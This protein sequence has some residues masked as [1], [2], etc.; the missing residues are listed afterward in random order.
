MTGAFSLP[1]LQA[2]LREG[3]QVAGVM[4]R[5]IG[6]PHRIEPP[7]RSQSGLPVLTTFV[8]PNIVQLA[9]Q[10]GIPVFEAG[11]FQDL[12]VLETVEPDVIAV[13]CFSR[14]LPA[15]LRG[16]ARLA[17]INVHPSLLP[18]NRGPDP[19][20]WTLA[21]GERQTGVTVHLLS[22]RADAGDILA[23]A[24][25]EVP[26]GI[27]RPDLERRCAGVGGEL[28]VEVIRQLQAGTATPIPQDESQA[29]YHR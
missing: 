22:D 12:R 27:T 25:V 23:Q 11:S 16:L 29:T 4:V 15:R 6:E 19:I 9:W 10:R 24:P 2:L 5:G 7:R 17:A 21:A 1:P 14:L 13:A 8:Q 3:I 28:L 18:R 26:A 20:G